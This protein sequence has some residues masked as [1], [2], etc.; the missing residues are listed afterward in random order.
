MANESAKESTGIEGRDD[1]ARWDFA[2]KGDGGED[3]LHQCSVHKPADIAGS[4]IT[5]FVFAN[6]RVAW[7]TAINEQVLDNDIARLS[8][9]WIGVLQEPGSEHNKEDLEDGMILDDGI[10]A[11]APRP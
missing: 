1:D 6:P 10:L 2:T 9:H 4:I 5:N 11:E 7:I 8:S 3:E